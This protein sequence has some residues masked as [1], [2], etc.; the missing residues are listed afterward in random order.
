MHHP[1]LE[2]DE[3][4]MQAR[5]FAFVV[6]PLQLATG[7]KKAI[8]GVGHRLYLLPLWHKRAPHQ[9]GTGTPSRILAEKFGSAS[10]SAALS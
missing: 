4:D 1:L 6:L 7:L 8:L 2:L 3:F 9:R 5:E 10:A